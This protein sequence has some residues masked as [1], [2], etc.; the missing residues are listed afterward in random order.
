MLQT[1]VTQR[2]PPLP[3]LQYYTIRTLWQLLFRG[4]GGW[5][6]TMALSS[7]S[8]LSRPRRSS[9]NFSW[10][11]T[12]TSES[13]TRSL[14]QYYSLSR[15]IFYTSSS[16]PIHQTTTV[17]ISS[18]TPKPLLPTPKNPLFPF[19]THSPSRALQNSYIKIDDNP[20]VSYLP[21][22]QPTLRTLPL[23]LRPP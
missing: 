3:S 1:R 19:R 21:E 13:I 4:G 5:G 6:G 9:R 23:Q 15:S 7:V 11:W 22:L 10:R 2:P 14:T 20:H 16:H 18:P 8:L 17:S 12:I